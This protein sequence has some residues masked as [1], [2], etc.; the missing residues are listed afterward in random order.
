M[1]ILIVIGDQDTYHETDFDLVASPMHLAE[2]LDDEGLT[3]VF[4]LHARR[5]EILAEQRR[6]DVIRALRRHEIGLHGRDLHPVVP[7]I[8]EGLGWYDG[9]AALLATEGAELEQLA[10]VFEVPPI[11]S[12]QHRNYAA[13]QIFGV[14][15]RLGLPY[16]F[17]YP[18]AP[19][20]HSVSWYAGALNIPFNAPVP[21][22]L[23]FF[24][25]VFDDVLPDDAAFAALF[26]RLREHVRRSLDV[27]LPL[28]VVFVCHPE[29]L[30]YSGPVE[31]W[32]YGNGV[33]HGRAAV[34]RGIE[35]RH[36]PGDVARALTNFRQVVR[37]LRDAPGLEPTTVRDVTRRYGVQARTIDAA[38]LTSLASRALDE[39]QIVLGASLG[40]AEA[41]LGMAESI[42]QYSRYG[43]LL[44]AIPRRDVLGPLASPPLAPATLT[45]G[46]DEVIALA[47]GLL[48]TT[49]ETGHLPAALQ[50][51]GPEIGLGSIY[52]VLAAAY[53]AARQD[54]LATEFTVDVWPRYPQLATALG[55]QHRLCVEDPLVRP[56]LSTDAAALHARLQSWTLK[57]AQ[58]T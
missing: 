20:H 49:N 17:G 46:V 9:V 47:D 23:G 13:P 1:D 10:R 54:S 29:R 26:N 43:Q 50:A 42:S 34:P 44:A 24:P 15:R 57:P 52:G 3:G 25:A 35:R 2:I 12:S 27:D 51:A 55:E 31:Q 19:P 38:E 6:H 28:L 22:F 4:V 41:L 40:P 11:G 30:Y 14:A 56:G 58:R 39:H 37:Y 53:V 32:L 21:N 16:L 7:E 48:R 18:A 45:L 8:V 33:N 36:G 5:A